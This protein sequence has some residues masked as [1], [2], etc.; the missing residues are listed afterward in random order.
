MDKAKQYASI[1]YSLL[2]IDV[3][4]LLA[5]LFLFQGLGLS[6]ALVQG[7][8]RVIHPHYFV[9]PVY[10]LVIYLAYYVLSFPLIFYR[11]F[12]LEHQFSLSIQKFDAWLKDEFKGGV[13]AYFILIILAGTFYYIYERYPGSWWFLLSLFWVFFSLILAKITPLVIIPLFF[14]YTSLSDNALRERI[15]KLAE[16]MQ[17]KIVDVFQIDFSKKTLKANAAFVGLGR[18]RRVLLADTLKDKYSIEEIEVILAHEFAHYKLRHLMKL[19]FINASFTVAA[20]Y[21][22]FKTA[23]YFLA[24]SGLS[25]LAD[26]AAF[27][28]LVIYFVIFGIITQPLQNY[29]SRIMEM[30]ADLM[31]LEVTQAKAAFISMMEKLS[32]QNLADRNPHPVIKFFFFDHPAIEERI[33]MAVRSEDS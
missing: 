31:A 21:F 32:S 26:L 27:P 16:K 3:G 4:Y 25:S 8:S 13:I 1:R 5:L 6:R 30:N 12:A 10:L 2:I 11:S 7:V 24:I 15:I 28:M 17:V 33:N 9:L 20:F 14:K 19:I 23:P 29:L 18:T 22:I